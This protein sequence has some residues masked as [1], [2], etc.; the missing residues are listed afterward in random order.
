MNESPEIVIRVL[1]WRVQG[2]VGPTLVQ[3]LANFLGILGKQ[4]PDRH[5]PSRQVSAGA[6]PSVPSRTARTSALST[7]SSKAARTSSTS[8]I[9]KL[10][11]SGSAGCS[12]ASFCQRYEGIIDD[13]I[14]IKDPWLSSELLEVVAKLLEQAEDGIVVEFAVAALAAPAARAG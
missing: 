10:W 2:D 12:P 13:R 4:A 14:G 11:G 1:V 7:S 5:A 8:S 9:T 6:L 3:Q